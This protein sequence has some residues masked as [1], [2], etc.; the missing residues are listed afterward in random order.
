[1]DQGLVPGDG[2]VQFQPFMRSLRESGYAGYLSLEMTF[3]YQQDP[4]SAG[5]RAKRFM[6]NLLREKA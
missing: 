5:Y 4:D 2:T 6:D 3:N 1:M